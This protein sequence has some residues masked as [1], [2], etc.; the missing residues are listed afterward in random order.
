MEGTFTWSGFPIS[1]RNNWWQHH[2]DFESTSRQVA[3]TTFCMAGGAVT[4]SVQISYYVIGVQYDPEYLQDIYLI[5]DSFHCHIH[6]LCISPPWRCACL[7]IFTPCQWLPFSPLNGLE[8]NKKEE[9]QGLKGT[10]APYSWC[11]IWNS[12]CHR[13]CSFS[14]PWKAFK[15]TGPGENITFFKSCKVHPM[16]VTMWP[17][18]ECPFRLSS[19]FKLNNLRL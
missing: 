14:T 8:T 7:W 6:M 11:I 10:L 17:T 3:G 18:L 13:G 16:M 15:W 2:K 12:Q 19:M 4:Y 1:C 9:V 5:S